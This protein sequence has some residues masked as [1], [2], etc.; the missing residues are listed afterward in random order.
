MI[1][2]F[3]SSACWLLNAN[4]KE[5]TRNH[6]ERGRTYQ[7][8][9]DVLDGKILQWNRQTYQHQDQR[10]LSAGNA[11]DRTGNNP[12]VNRGKL[13]NMERQNDCSPKA[14]GSFTGFE[15][16]NSRSY[17]W[18][19]AQKIWISIKERY[20]SSQSSNR[21]RMFNKFLYIKFQEDAVETLW[22][23]YRRGSDC[24][25]QQLL[26]LMTWSCGK[27]RRTKVKASFYRRWRAC[28]WG[29]REFPDKLLKPL[30]TPTIILKQTRTKVWK[31]NGNKAHLDVEEEFKFP[32]EEQQDKSVN[33]QS[34]ANQLPSYNHGQNEQ[35][36][37]EI[38]NQLVQNAPTLPNSQNLTPITITRTLR[39]CS[40]LK[41][42]MRYGFHHYFEPNTFKSAI[43]CEDAKH[44]KR[45]IEKEV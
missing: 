16:P 24:Q 13:L 20:A 28:G 39:D 45:A 30:G 38:N 6:R 11:E 34:S 19:S 12:P 3:F 26:P 42:P 40:Q 36:E 41:P 18:E 29:V 25:S 23:L 32:L 21:A 27:L 8:T 33:S 43:R 17:N 7:A 35:D 1:L 37:E 4:K 5:P 31:D 9:T 2:M 15:T 14:T 10:W 44:W 22:S